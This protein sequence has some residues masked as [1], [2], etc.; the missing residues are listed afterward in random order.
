[1]TTPMKLNWLGQI[2]Q[3]VFII[4]FN[5]LWNENS[6]AKVKGV[7]SS[8]IGRSYLNAMSMEESEQVQYLEQFTFRQSKILNTIT[9]I[10]K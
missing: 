1:M 5:S 3:S 9:W 4:W 6:N 2:W 10:I 7:N 8:V